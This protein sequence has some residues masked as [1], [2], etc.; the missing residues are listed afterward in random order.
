MKKIFVTFAFV[1][2]SLTIMQ[3]NDKAV[4]FDK[5]PKK[6]HTNVIVLLLPQS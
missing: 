2:A 6:A 5:L 1:L 3:A 4:T